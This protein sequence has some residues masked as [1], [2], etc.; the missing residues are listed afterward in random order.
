[1]VL[2][3]WPCTSSSW[4]W[5]FRATIVWNTTLQ[6]GIIDSSLSATIRVT[7]G[8][9][10]ATIFI[11]RR[12]RPVPTRRRAVGDA[13]F[14]RNVPGGPRST[15]IIDTASSAVAETAGIGVNEVNIRVELTLNDSKQEKKEK[16]GC[17]HTVATK[18]FAFSI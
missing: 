16:Q 10:G 3:F 14:N 15:A 13:I 7:T 5:S 6:V 4:C 9:F 2:G 1:M 17:T 18:D 12:K 8:S 11:A